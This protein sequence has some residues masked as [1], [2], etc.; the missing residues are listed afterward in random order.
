MKYFSAPV[1]KTEACK[2]PLLFLTDTKKKKDP[3]SSSHWLQSVLP[4]VRGRSLDKKLHL[5]LIFFSLSVSTCP[6]AKWTE[7]HFRIKSRKW[8]AAWTVCSGTTPHVLLIRRGTPTTPSYAG[9]TLCRWSYLHC[10]GPVY[11][12]AVELCWWALWNWLSV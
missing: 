12:W 11:F 7:K 4:T 1:Q 9:S 10:C 6:N 8:T 2:F 5:N 3:C